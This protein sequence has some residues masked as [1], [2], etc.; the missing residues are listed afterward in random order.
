MTI[1]PGYVFFCICS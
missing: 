1:K